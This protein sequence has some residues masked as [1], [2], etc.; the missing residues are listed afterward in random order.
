MKKDLLSYLTTTTAESEESPVSSHCAVDV[1]WGLG[2]GDTEIYGLLRR[3]LPHFALPHPPSLPSRKIP[4]KQQKRPLLLKA[5]HSPTFMGPFRYRRYTALMGEQRKGSIS[6]PSFGQNACHRTLR[7]QWKPSSV[8]DALLAI[9]FSEL[10]I[11]QEGTWGLRCHE[12]LD[13]H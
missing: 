9:L 12:T 10:H 8:R 5:A 6:R 3:R 7:Q 4:R 11:L 2:N 1:V 13:I